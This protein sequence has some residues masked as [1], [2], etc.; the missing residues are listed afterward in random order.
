MSIRFGLRTGCDTRSPLLVCRG[1]PP[2]RSSLRATG[3][4]EAETTEPIDAFFFC[5]NDLSGVGLLWSPP[6]PSSC[7]WGMRSPETPHCPINQRR[8]SVF[9]SLTSIPSTLML[10]VVEQPPQWAPLLPAA[11]NEFLIPPAWSRAPPCLTS[12][13]S[14]QGLPGARRRAMGWSFPLP[15]FTSRLKPK[16]ELG[17]RDLGPG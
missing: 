5:R 16:P 6:A 1:P 4:S 3:H 14:C 13:T 15:C 17:R 12:S 11:S 10:A 8:W 7:P 2:S 9:H